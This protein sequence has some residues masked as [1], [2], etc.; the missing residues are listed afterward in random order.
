MYGSLGLRFYDLSTKH[1]SGLSNNAFPPRAI[2][3]NSFKET[4]K[5]RNS[6]LCVRYLDLGVLW[7]TSC[8]LLWVVT[9]AGC[10]CLPRWIAR[11][12]LTGSR[13]L[14]QWQWMWMVQ[15][16]IPRIE[17]HLD[18]RQWTWRLLRSYVP[19]HSRE[20]LAPF[21]RGNLR[22]TTLSFTVYLL[23]HQQR[24]KIQKSVCGGRVRNIRM[25]SRY[26]WVFLDSQGASDSSGILLGNTFRSIRSIW[27]LW[28]SAMISS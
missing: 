12:L 1:A 18:L 19:R 20:D 27:A 4:A 10:L 17:S 15:D 13:M 24:F 21:T 5:P 16:V 26:Q 14:H 25:Y 2:P 6:D 23:N 3:V 11:P 22:H 7:Y 28:W 8:E 9:G